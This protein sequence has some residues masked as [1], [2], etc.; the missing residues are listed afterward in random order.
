MT[1]AGREFATADVERSKE[2]FRQ[3]LLKSVPTTE[4][5]VSMLRRKQDGRVGKEFLLDILDEHFSAG[6]AQRQFDRL[7]DWGRY[8]AL[9]EYDADEERLYSVD[10]Q[11][12]SVRSD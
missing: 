6:E 3:Q 1:S 8:A 12:E 5:I 4:S 9:F 2:L 7:V 11:E 10:A